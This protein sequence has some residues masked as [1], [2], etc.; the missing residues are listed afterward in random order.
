MD[1]RS[2]GPAGRGRDGAGCSRTGRLGIRHNL[3]GRGCQLQHQVHE[4]SDGVNAAAAGD[5]LLVKGTCTG[6]TRIFKDLT[7]TGQ[8]SGGTKTATL[9]GGGLY[10]GGVATV[11]L[12]SLVITQ[13]SGITNDGTLI[14]NGGTIT[15]NAGNSAGAIF[16]NGTVTLNGD[17][18]ITGNTGST[19]GAIFNNGTVTLNG[20]TAYRQHRRRSHRRRHRQQRQRHADHERHAGATGTPR[21]AEAL[22][23]GAPIPA[24][25]NM[26]GNSASPATAPRR[27]RGHLQQRRTVTMNGSSAI[28]GNTATFSGGGIFENCGAPLVGVTARN[29]Y[30][31]T[32]DNINNGGC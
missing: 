31:N 7:I 6:D 19:A 12:N 11:T 20:N 17:T 14:L 30:G 9:N 1:S 8:S 5:T 3:R 13:G 26:N 15:G 10:I 32:P 23:A 25:L 28:T 4:S 18:A 22:K 29:V 2:G 24:T 27:R 16:N 21:P